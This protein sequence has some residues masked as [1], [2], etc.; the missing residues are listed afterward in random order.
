MFDLRLEVGRSQGPKPNNI[1]TENSFL[2]GEFV[3]LSKYAVYT[4]GLL[5]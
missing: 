5:Y 4:G 1:F 2:S 3:E